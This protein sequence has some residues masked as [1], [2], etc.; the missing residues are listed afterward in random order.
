MDM[1]LQQKW[2]SKYDSSFKSLSSQLHPY[3]VTS[4]IEINGMEWVENPLQKVV[5]NNYKQHTI[6]ALLKT[7]DLLCAFHS[8]LRQHLHGNIPLHKEQCTS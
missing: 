1:W 6:D 5:E 8:R 4:L 2:L 7:E 3:K